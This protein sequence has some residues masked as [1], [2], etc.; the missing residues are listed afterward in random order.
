MHTIVFYFVIIYIESCFHLIY[1]KSNKHDEDDFDWYAKRAEADTVSI[2]FH[3]H[4]NPLS[5]VLFGEHSSS[6][7]TFGGISMSGCLHESTPGPVGSH[8]RKFICYFIAVWHCICQFAPTK[9]KWDDM[10]TKF[11]GRREGGE[12]NRSGFVDYARLARLA[13]LAPL[14][15]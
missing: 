8:T 6:W 15:Y 5:I 10:K 4:Y 9:I 3:S 1:C 14:N 13:R 2:E 12:A 7:K 11:S